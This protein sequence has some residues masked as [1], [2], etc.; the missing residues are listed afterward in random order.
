VKKRSLASRLLRLVFLWIPAAFI[1]LSLL[2]VL[3][4]KWVP[5][6]V[7]PLMV[8]RAVEYRSDKDFH[9]HYK[10]VPYSKM[11]PELARAVIASE[12]NLFLQHD[13]FDR[14]AI[15]QA[16]KEKKE[17]RALRGASTISQQT[18][19]NVF[20]SQR[21]SWVRKGFEAYFTVLIELIWGK[22]RILEVYLNVAEMGKGIYGAQAAAKAYWGENASAVSRRQAC[23]LAACLPSPLKR[24]PVRPGDY[25][26]RRAYAIASLESKL[27]YPDWI[28]HK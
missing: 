28:Y 17:G 7:T 12:D 5:P 3:L 1:V 10:W 21:R 14:G 16:L 18:A 4:L 11:S 8:H 19:K 26:S 27:S 23:L 25:T 13:G 22:R 2:W 20:C 15:R 9:T 6:P 24:S